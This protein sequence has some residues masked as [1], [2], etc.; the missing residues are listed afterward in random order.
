M[1]FVNESLTVQHNTIKAS[2]Q[3]P[4]R[5]SESVILIARKPVRWTKLCPAWR[6]EYATCSIDWSHV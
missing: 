1:W 6:E 3:R 2:L 4:S 5:F